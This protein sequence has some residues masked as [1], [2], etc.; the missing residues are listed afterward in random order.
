MTDRERTGA[1]AMRLPLPEQIAS[2]ALLIDAADEPSRDLILSAVNGAGINAA[3]P[4][5]EISDKEWDDIF[6][7]NLL[8]VKVA[9]QV[10]GEAMLK[11]E[12]PGSIINIASI[13]RAG[14]MG[15]TNYGAT[16]SGGS[17]L[18]PTLARS[19]ARSGIRR[20]RLLPSIHTAS[21]HDLT[22]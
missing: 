6:R 2:M 7:V 1:A 12:I 18:V 10:F 14:N 20:A 4:F 9:C 21:A 22:V 8:S 5:L 3:T 13:S 17:A 16:K 15:Q 11:Q 19:L